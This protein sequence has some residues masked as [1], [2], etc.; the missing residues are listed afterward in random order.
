MSSIEDGASE[1]LRLGFCHAIACLPHLAQQLHAHL[2]QLFVPKQHGHFIGVLLDR[3]KAYLNHGLVIER[4]KFRQ[5]R[6]LL[7]LNQVLQAI[8]LIDGK[9]LLIELAQNA[10]HQAPENAIAAELS[11]DVRQVNRPIM[12]KLLSERVH[13]EDPESRLVTCFQPF[14]RVE[15]ER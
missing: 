8:A 1:R 2:S 14:V 5:F 9:F 7:L 3:F 10:R 12:S 11:K 4:L 6:H 13:F 15:G